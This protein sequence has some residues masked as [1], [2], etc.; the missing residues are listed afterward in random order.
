MVVR[1]TRYMITIKNKITDD[2]LVEEDTVLDGM[3]AGSAIVR[4]GKKLIINGMI[5]GNV[6]IEEDAQVELNGIVAG[7]IYNQ[8]GGF[9]KSG[10]LAGNLVETD[11]PS[12]S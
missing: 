5:T 3:V 12:P 9:V 11:S 10:I 7:D 1:Y 4:P 8:G 6:V 2:L